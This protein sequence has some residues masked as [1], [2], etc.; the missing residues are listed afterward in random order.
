MHKIMSNS[1][2]VMAEFPSEDRAS[3]IKGLH[4][5]TDDIPVQCSLGISW[6]IVTDTFTFEVQ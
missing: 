3:S 2:V 4:F 1:A 6:N 5:A